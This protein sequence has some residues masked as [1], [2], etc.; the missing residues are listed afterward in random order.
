MENAA[1][2]PSPLRNMI[3]VTYTQKS[4]RVVVASHTL[5]NIYIYECTRLYYMLKI[6]TV[7]EAIATT[8]RFITT[9][10]VGLFCCVC[11]GR[12]YTRNCRVV[13]GGVCARSSYVSSARYIRINIC[14]WCMPLMALR[15]VDGKGFIYMFWNRRRAYKYI[16]YIA[17]C[18]QIRLDCD[19]VAYI[20]HYSVYR[21]A[22]NI[23]ALR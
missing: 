10:S 19:S 11:V 8:K 9:F 6:C 16:V 17:T 18:I 22:R 20:L 21:N 12:P 13:D 4:D 23:L 3:F 5:N 7:H 14:M 1:A 15:V 2:A